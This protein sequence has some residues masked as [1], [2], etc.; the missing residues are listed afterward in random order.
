MFQ[1]SNRLIALLLAVALVFTGCGAATGASSASSSSAAASSAA[2]SSAQSAQAQFPVTVTDALGRTVTVTAEPQRIVSG[3]YITSSLLIAL[4]LQDKTVGIEAKA[5][6]RPIYALA[7][8]EMLKLPNV[9]TAKEF[10]LEGCAALKPDLVILPVKLKESVAALE[11]LGVTVVA[12]NPENVEQLYAAIE[13]I[14]A[15][16][17]TAERAQQ[18]VDFSQE[19]YAMLAELAKLE[20]KPRVYL[21]GNASLLSTAGAKM[22]QNSV[23]EAAGG[24]NVAAELEDSYW[25]EVSYEQL[26]AWN[27]EVIVIAPGADYTAAEVLADP[28]LAGVE[29][30]TNGAVYQMPQT[31]EA[32]DSPV[33]STVL[34]SLWLASVLHPQQYKPEQFINDTAAYYNAF[35][36]VAINP[37]L[38]G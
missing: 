33:P 1:K 26:L 4:G 19:R 32:W 24:V 38:L 28:Q 12:V 30:V 25:A 23:I 29:A 14:G 27:P 11:Q 17:G 18:L 7:A 22:Y 21:G 34:G 8:P 5:D 20:K 10:D 15:A 35:C 6:T 36:G 2:Q 16:T 31:V 3:Y 13:M 9:G 37:S